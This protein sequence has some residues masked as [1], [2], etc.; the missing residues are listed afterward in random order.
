M[1]FRN[2]FLQGLSVIAYIM[3][4]LFAGHM[5]GAEGMLIAAIGPTTLGDSGIQKQ[6]KDLSIDAWWS[7]VYKSSFSSPQYTGTTKSRKGVGKMENITGPPLVEYYDLR[8]RKGDV[9]TDTIHIP[10]F[11]GDGEVLGITGSD[12]GYVRVKGQQRKDFEIK[13]GR[14]NIS[15][16]LQEHFMSIREDDVKMS[17]QELGGNLLELM[18]R[19]LTDLRG[20]YK[21][22]DIAFSIYQGYSPHLYY[23]QAQSDASISNG[24]PV[25]AN[26]SLSLDPTSEHPNSMAWVNTGTT[27]D[28][29][30]KMVLANDI[31]DATANN[32]DGKV[33]E[34]MGQIDSS[35][36]PGRKMLDAI[37][38]QLIFHNVVPIR[39]RYEGAEKACYI[40]PISPAMRNII[41]DD[42]AL[43]RIFNAAMQGEMYKHP[44]IKD[45]D[46]MYRGLILRNEEKFDQEW[47]TAKY[48]FGNKAYNYG[49]TAS[50]GTDAST[51]LA[52]GNEV[53]PVKYV[54]SGSGRETRNYLSYT[55][56]TFRRYISDGDTNLGGTG[57][58]SAD[59]Q[60]AGNDDA[61][62]AS[63]GDKIDRIP[64]LGASALGIVQGTVHP[65]ERRKEDDYDNITGIG[66]P[67]M[68]G[69]RRVEWNS[70][71]GHASGKDNQGSLMVAAFNGK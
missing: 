62:G 56:R 23:R 2:L 70:V 58:R 53:E 54:K 47:Y 69:C 59:A 40:L 11:Y 57:D 52:T 35:A 55:E 31:D 13:A 15:F 34:A 42:P 63:G 5:F 16:P 38:A 4:I 36:I 8:N 28:P 17:E 39:L 24:D 44:F 64:V 6:W 67:S 33:H 50:G 19:H 30:L 14:Q 46:L 49:V 61:I 32:W 29:Q 21:D 60:K 18:I 45:D 7:A 65:L 12:A 27:S 41:Q 48:G 10:P 43:E 22:A 37:W 26:A 66:Q 20:R 71:R 51:G 68:C 3:F 1:K 9:L 25:K